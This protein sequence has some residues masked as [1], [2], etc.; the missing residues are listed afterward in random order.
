MMPERMTGWHWWQLVGTCCDLRR[1][2][3]NE[4][5]TSDY[6]SRDW[7]DLKQRLGTCVDTLF[8]DLPC[9]HSLYRYWPVYE[10]SLV[11][12]ITLHLRYY[13][14]KQIPCLCLYR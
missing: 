7:N 11:I 12:L 2:T 6:V 1:F 8:Y 5:P 4:L 13:R 14:G 10:L 9:Y 3:W